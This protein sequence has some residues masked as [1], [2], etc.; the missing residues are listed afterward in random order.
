MET[1]NVL[2]TGI[3]TKEVESLKA[4]T[5]KVIEVK[6]EN[7][8]AAK[9]DKVIFTVAHPDRPEP[10]QIS[11]VRYM[12][13]DAV[14]TS[15]TWIKM[16]EDNLLQKGSALTKLLSFNKVGTV[17]ELVGKDIATELDVKGYLAFK[18]Y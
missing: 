13:H 12:M 10:I 15:G 4:G 7:V 3:G 17:K 18:A 14:K 11:S 16:D 2:E 9:G 8:P 1:Q 6:V 5:V